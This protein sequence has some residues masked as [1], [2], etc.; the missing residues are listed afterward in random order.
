MFSQMQIFSARSLEP[1]ED[2]TQNDARPPAVIKVIGFG[3][4]GT[5]A[6]NHMIN[7]GLSGV[8]FMAALENQMTYS[9]LVQAASF[10]FSQINQV[11]RN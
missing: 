9:L 3:S 2:T 6:I 11:L 7:S 1:E 5:N 8:E 10:E 4:G